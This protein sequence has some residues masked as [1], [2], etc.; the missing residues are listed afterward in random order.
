MIRVNKSGN[1]LTVYRSLP[2]ISSSTSALLTTDDNDTSTQ[3]KF[4]ECECVKGNTYFPIN[5]LR[6][7]STCPRERN[8]FG[9]YLMKVVLN[10][11]TNQLRSLLLSLK[12][13]HF[14]N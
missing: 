5:F 12:Q 2:F 7:T 6:F 8:S 11:D 14:Q 10:S 3:E 13:I 4:I 1:G 9:L